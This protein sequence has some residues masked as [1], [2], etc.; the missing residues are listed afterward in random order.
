MTSLDSILKNRDITLPKKGP[1]S[2]TYRFSKSHE[3][4]WELDY[5]E[6]WVLKNWYFWTVVSEETFESLFDYKKIQV[7]PKGNQSWIFIGRT[8]AEAETSILWTHD[9]KNW[10]IWKDPDAG[11]IEGGRRRGRLRMKWLDG[12]TDSMDMSLSKL[13]AL[14]MD[15][16]VWYAAVH[17]VSKS[18]TQVSNWTVSN[19]L[20]FIIKRINSMK[21]NTSWIDIWKFC[22]LSS[23]SRIKIKKYIEIWKESNLKLQRLIWQFIHCLYANFI[24]TLDRG[25]L[26][27]IPSSQNMCSYQVPKSL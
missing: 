27:S 12:I 14:V 13:R 18:R 16:E 26:L 17:G 22:F 23:Y 5:K 21:L 10:L 15:R 11:K 20:Y 25:W 19:C 6:N 24:F 9:V 8:D 7:H 2:P 3:W 4:M 1:S